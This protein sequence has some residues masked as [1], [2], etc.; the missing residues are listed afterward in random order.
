[1]AEKKGGAYEN[2]QLLYGADNVSLMMATMRRYRENNARNFDQLRLAMKA[3]A[4]KVRENRA[5]MEKGMSG[6]NKAYLDA[7]GA[8]SQFQA[9]VKDKKESLNI[10]V[11]IN[12]ILLA[13]GKELNK[14][15][16]DIGANGSQQAVSFATNEII[17]E[18]NALKTQLTNVYNA[19]AE[20]EAAK[21]LPPGEKEAIL[22]NSNPDLQLLFAKMEDGQ[23]NI[24]IQQ[25]P[26]TKNW[27]LI[28]LDTEKDRKSMGEELDERMK[29][30]ENKRRSGGTAEDTQYNTA[31]DRE[32]KEL[33]EEKDKIYDAA[34]DTYKPEESYEKYRDGKEHYNYDPTIGVIEMA[35][36]QPIHGGSGNQY[37]AH[38]EEVE[39][40]DFLERHNKLLQENPN[41]FGTYKFN[42]DGTLDF[43]DKA[44]TGAS[45]G[46]QTYSSAQVADYYLNRGGV[47]LLDSYLNEDNLDGQLESLIGSDVGEYYLD[48][49]A[50][51]GKGFV[52]FE[53]M[54]PEDKKDEIRYLMLNK[55]LE[56]NPKLYDKSDP[57][58]LGVEANEDFTTATR[59]NDNV[60]F[61][62]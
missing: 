4:D 13:K 44:P 5:F 61:N 54:T 43:N 40:E 33:E 1:M 26:T 51:G 50:K 21:A 8:L 29:S 55:I 30:L 56:T 19:H 22:S 11:Q 3:R 17:A 31:L 46:G 18:I 38:A 12:N 37:F 34:T 59:A 6:Y 32:I 23:E 49:A 28:P 7:K 10:G 24:I 58:K 41:L 15:L 14:R 9:G 42:Q 48:N 20:W 25:D 47:A 16:T 52:D 62:F 39:Q 36:I 60:E 45:Q 35:N 27:V 53:D 2:P 57:N